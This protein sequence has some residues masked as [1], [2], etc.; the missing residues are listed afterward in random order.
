M[1]GLE[2]NGDMQVLN[3]EGKVIEGLYAA[4]NN[5]GSFFGG[6]V[7]RMCCPGFGVGRAMLTGRVAAKRALG[8]N[9]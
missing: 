6:L 7:Q 5:S 1:G 2:V 3:R 9:Y 4:G 8:T